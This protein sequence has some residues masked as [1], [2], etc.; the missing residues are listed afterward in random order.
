MLPGSTIACSFFIFLLRQ[1]T[2]KPVYNNH[3]WDHYNMVIIDW[4]LLYRNTGSNDHLI[5]WSL[6][7]GF[8]KK[9]A[10]QI[11]HENYLWW[12]EPFTKSVEAA[13]NLT[14]LVEVG[15]HFTKFIKFANNITKFIEFAINFTKFVLANNFYEVYMLWTTL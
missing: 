3:F 10:C 9:S 7:A 11:W 5:K 8:L 4:W 14:K 6:C 15:K 1:Y 12:N 13:N 2:V